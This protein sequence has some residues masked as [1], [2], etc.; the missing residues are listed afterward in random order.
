MLTENK[1]KILDVVYKSSSSPAAFSNIHS[2]YEIAKTKDQTITQK[3]V[4]RYLH[5]QA[6]YTRHV[7]PRRS[8]Q[9]SA[10]LAPSIDY[11]WY[12]ANYGMYANFVC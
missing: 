1:I 8:F 6:T 9:R 7:L 4:I 10:I 5:S 3:D 2:V 11:S 12:K